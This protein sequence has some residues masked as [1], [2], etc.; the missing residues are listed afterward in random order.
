MAVV[1]SGP[2]QVLFATVLPPLSVFCAVGLHRQF[3]LNLVFT[4]LGYVP[5]VVHAFHVFL[6]SDSERSP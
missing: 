1:I 4:L 2:M 6:I 5:G 3:W